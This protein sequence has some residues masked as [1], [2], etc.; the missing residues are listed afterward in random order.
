M[1]PGL[2]STQ[3]VTLQVYSWNKKGRSEVTI[4]AQHVI[5]T[6]DSSS[7]STGQWQIFFNQR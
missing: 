3:P 6:S 2:H 5:I 4:I 7:Q 1:L